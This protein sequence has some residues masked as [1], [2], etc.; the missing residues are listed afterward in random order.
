MRKLYQIKQTNQYPKKSRNKENKNK[1]P[2]I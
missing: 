2:K 1:N